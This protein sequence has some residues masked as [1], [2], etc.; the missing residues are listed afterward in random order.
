MLVFHDPSG[1]PNNPG[2]PLRN[3]LYY[4]QAFQ[5]ILSVT[6]LCLRQGEASRVAT[7]SAPEVIDP[8]AVK[9]QAVGWE[10]DHNGALTSKRA[11]LGASLDPTR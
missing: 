11:D 6:V 5:G 2:W 8:A 9:P 7:V 10:R 4:L 1:L 3:A